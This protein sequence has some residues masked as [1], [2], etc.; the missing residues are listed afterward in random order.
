MR[1]DASLAALG[2]AIALGA[3]AAAEP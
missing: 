1:Y 3:L 2:V